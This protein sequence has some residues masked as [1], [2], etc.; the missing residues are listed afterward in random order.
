MHSPK[1]IYFSSLK[2]KLGI[3]EKDCNRNE[4]FKKYANQLFKLS[5]FLHSKIVKHEVK[6]EF[7]Y[8]YNFYY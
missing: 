7:F 6:I 8:K 2:L 4:L 3:F 1:S 5:K